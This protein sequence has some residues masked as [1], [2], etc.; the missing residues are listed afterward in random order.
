MVE[1][2]LTEFLGGDFCEDKMVIEWQRKSHYSSVLLVYCFSLQ[3]VS[4]TGKKD[5]QMLKVEW[6]VDW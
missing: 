5:E 3:I 2:W 4:F 6:F 1:E